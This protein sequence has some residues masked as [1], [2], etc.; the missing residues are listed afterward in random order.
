[1]R[2]T[3]RPDPHRG[4]VP[5]PLAIALLAP[6]ACVGAIVG[7]GA[8]PG[9]DPG[10]AIAGGRNGAQ[11]L[12]GAGPGATPGAGGPTAGA[13]GA[14]ATGAPATPASCAPGARG[15][16]AGLRRL[17]RREY[18]NT[19]ADL[20]GDRSSPARAFAPEGGTTGF[21][22]A[23][24]GVTLS[25]AVVEQYVEAARVVAR[26]AVKNVPAL[27]ACDVAARGE[28]ACARAFIAR[29]GRRAFR[30]PLTPE[31][32]SRYEG[33]YASSKAA[34]GFAAALELTL[35]AFLVAPQFLYRIEIGAGPGSRPGQIR[36]APH[37]LATR[38]SYLFWATTPDEALLQAAE[39]GQLGTPPQV[40]AQARRLLGHAHGGRLLR[41]FHVQW[42]GLEGL[43]T[44]DRGPRYAPALGA[45]MRG[46]AE[47]YFDEMI[48]ARGAGFADLM[49]S[50]L[51][52]ANADL[53]AIY[54]VAGVAGGEPREIT[55]PAAR[56]RG[57]LTLAAFLTAQ[58]LPSEG[59]PIV[60]GKFLREELLCEPHLVPPPD[61]NPVI[62]PPDAQKTARQQLEERTQAVEPCRTCHVRINV[63]GFAF[64]RFD[65]TGRWREADERGRPID[66][67]GALVGT[68]VDG[69]F[70][71][72]T[73][74]VERLARSRQVMGCVAT[75]WFR[76]VSGRREDDA[77][78]C[79]RAELAEAFAASRGDV[80]VLVERLVTSD[81]FLSK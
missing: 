34:H 56:H 41:D 60:R 18:D 48:R 13:P 25:D 8:G 5:A 2:R 73:E 29:F 15:P 75:H 49:T 39:A 63:P 23:A 20:L 30:R 61:V 16:A 32:V 66:V 6:L 11:G 40:A 19:V 38:L 79:L 36:L 14:P 71:G 55:R 77:D 78:A 76:Y 68:D 3:L 45:V 59:S 53:A 4:I 69:S 54:G 17:T 74:L 1:M 64:G 81:V 65:Q 27:L 70:S 22:T 31:E 24:D 9:E 12:P 26:T 80:R 28:D 21:D 57:F 37:E 33:F 44:L 7:E 35:R 58:A 50:P 52:F 72:H 62:P 42:L 47:T 46:E 67:A 51:G 43:A 10:G